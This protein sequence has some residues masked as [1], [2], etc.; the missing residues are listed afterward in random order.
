MRNLPAWAFSVLAVVGVVM[1][2][3][4]VLPWIDVSGFELSATGVSMA[5][6]DNH[7]MFLVPAAG[8]M[9][10]AAAATRSKHT[11]LAACFAGLVVAGDVIYS[12]AS[13]ILTMSTGSWL[14]VGGALAVLLGVPV[15]RRQLRIIGGL[16][17]VVGFFVAG[18]IHTDA[19][20]MTGSGIAI[21]G[22][23][24]AISGTSTSTKAGWVAL[25]AGAS[26][27]AFIALGIGFTAFVVFGIGAWSA[28]GASLA[29]LVIALAVPATKARA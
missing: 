24:A 5:W 1:V 14:V 10:T 7:W 20:S 8:A 4:M 26:P 3:A 22:V 23:V 18:G 11:R 19:M 29:A 12:F 15:A 2:V 28:F 25:I 6:H 21:A 13:D 27:F 9:L 16:A 17:M